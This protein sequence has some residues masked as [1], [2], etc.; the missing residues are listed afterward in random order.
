MKNVHFE[1]LVNSMQ[2]Q[3]RST[4]WHSAIDRSIA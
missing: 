4:N 3:V 2:S 1:Y